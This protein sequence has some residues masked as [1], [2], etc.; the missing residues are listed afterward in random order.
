MLPLDAAVL[1]LS[2][3]LAG[4]ILDAGDRIGTKQFLELVESAG[5]SHKLQ[6]LNN[7]TMFLPNDKAIKVLRLLSQAHTCKHIDSLFCSTKTWFL[8]NNGPFVYYPFDIS[9]FYNFI[10]T[11]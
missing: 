7:F 2:L 11:V 9:L 1:T 4:D 6:N 10:F 8:S 5:L 3:F